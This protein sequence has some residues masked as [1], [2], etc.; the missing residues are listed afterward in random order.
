MKKMYYLF[1]TIDPNATKAF[2]EMQRHQYQVGIYILT[3]RIKAKA[4]EQI[5]RKIVFDRIK[6]KF[7]SCV[8][9]LRYYDYK[10]Y[11]FGNCFKSDA[12]RKNC[13]FLIIFTIILRYGG[14]YMILSYKSSYLPLRRETRV[15]A[16]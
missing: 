7:I 11:P 10:K 16:L 2:I 13:R 9:F 15:L 8:I 14:Q 1:G 6:L 5:L 12:L 3:G 4:I